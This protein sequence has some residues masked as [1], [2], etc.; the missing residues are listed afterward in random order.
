MKQKTTLILITCLLTASLLLAIGTVTLSWYQSRNV[1]DREVKI[2]ADGYIVV[3]FDENPVVVDGIL[4]PAICMPNAVRDNQYFD[5]LKVYNQSDDV[6]SYVETPATTHTFT[7]TVTFYEDPTKT[8]TI[9]SYDFMLTTQ[10]YVK[11]GAEETKYNINTSREINFEIKADIN[12]AD[13]Q[14]ET[15]VVITPGVAYNLKGSATIKLT[16]KM[17][18]ALPDELCDPVLIDNKLYCEFGIRVDP[19]AK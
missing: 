19:V 5:V 13:G 7:E 6:V 12:Y 3:G 8:E 14:K 11:L 17:W 4:K 2:P 16:I 1:T 10:A 15:D 18:L 9:G